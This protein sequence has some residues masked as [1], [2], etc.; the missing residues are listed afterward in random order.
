MSYNYYFYD[1]QK[2]INEIKD[3][4]QEIIT[5]IKHDNEKFKIQKLDILNFNKSKVLETLYIAFNGK[6]IETPIECIKILK[7]Y[8]LHKFSYLLYNTELLEP[9]DRIIFDNLKNK[10]LI[11]FNHINNYMPTDL[12]LG[13]QFSNITFIN[14][15]LLNVGYY[16]GSNHQKFIYE[17]INSDDFFTKLYYLN[18]KYEILSN[19]IVMLILINYLDYSLNEELNTDINP[20]FLKKKYSFAIDFIKD[21]I[22]NNTKP[23]YDINIDNSKF[24]RNYFGY[25]N[26]LAN[27]DIHMNKYTYARLSY[28]FYLIFYN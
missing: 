28:L 11:I 22:S 10:L 8:Y 2:Q 1:K 17:N 9:K 27:N 23:D 21:L 12:I 25:S 18:K 3:K 6:N 26:Y 20:T 7:H 16:L 13:K 15:Y 14:I 19:Y 4:K 5:N 24:Y